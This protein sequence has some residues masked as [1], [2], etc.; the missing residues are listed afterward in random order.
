[1]MP[2]EYPRI[3]Q[4]LLRLLV[5]PISLRVWLILGGLLTMLSPVTL[6]WLNRSGDYYV[7]SA[8]A[9][10]DASPVCNAATIARVNLLILAVLEVAWIISIAAVAL[11]STGPKR[12]IAGRA[13]IM[14]PLVAGR[15]R[16][17]GFWSISVAIGHLA[18]CAVAFSVSDVCG[19]TSFGSR[20]F[21]YWGLSGSILW[22]CISSAILVGWIL[23]LLKQRLIN[24]TLE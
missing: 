18:L 15:I 23:I 20:I 17:I 2:A 1:M 24:Q 11:M 10:H 7:W 9:P 8:V 14:K 21:V 22:Y 6:F 13:K 12:A 3:R 4:Q 5:P 19:A 16:K